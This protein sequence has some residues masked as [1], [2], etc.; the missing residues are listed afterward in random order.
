MV[1][2]GFNCYF[3]FWAI[4]YP[5]TSIT[6]QKIKNLEKMKKKAW[7]YHFT[8]VYQKSLSN[9]ILFLKYGV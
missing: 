3:S 9:A 1:H 4:F 2:N 6:A 5:F 8:I 7:R